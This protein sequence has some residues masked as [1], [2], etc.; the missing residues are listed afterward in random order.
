ME[1][2]FNKNNKNILYIICLVFINYIIK[3]IYLNDII[4][5][6]QFKVIFIAF[7]LSS[8]FLIYVFRSKFNN[9]YIILSFI[10]AIIEGLLNTASSI[11]YYYSNIC[12]VLSLIFFIF[13]LLCIYKSTN[14]TTT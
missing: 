8:L 4:S 14:S 11:L 5:I 7:N 6:I 13:T 2:I 10:F 1:K 12:E 9:R 3:L